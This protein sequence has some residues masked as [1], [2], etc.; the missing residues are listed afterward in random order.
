MSPR[1]AFT[2]SGCQRALLTALVL[3]GATASLS[4]AQEHDASLQARFLKE[5]PQRWAEYATQAKHLQGTCSSRGYASLSKTRSNYEGTFREN[6]SSKLLLFSS[7]RITEEPKRADRWL[8]AVVVNP[9]YAFALKRRTPDGAWFVKELIDL[10]T[11]TLR[12]SFEILID[13]FQSAT[14]EPVGFGSFAV[15]NRTG[16]RSLSH[17]LQSP[18]FRVT[19]CVKSGSAGQD[20]VEVAF[21]T[22][23]EDTTNGIVGGTLFLDPS[24]FW[25]MQSCEVRTQDPGAAMRGVVKYRVLEWG[26]PTAPIP[27]PK[28]SVLEFEFTL[29]DGK[30]GKS[31]WHNEK[32]L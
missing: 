24:R 9:L 18:G 27:W 8:E 28:R 4:G 31:D 20:L 11:Q 14:V 22:S 29:K 2:L 6:G 26:G 1:T 13:D 5:A 23:A 21:E 3:A 7:E 32:D 12:P 15:N 17:L 30:Q 16:A 10:R 25:C 19:R